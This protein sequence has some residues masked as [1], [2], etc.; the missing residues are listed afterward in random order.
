LKLKKDY[1]EILVSRIFSLF[2]LIIFLNQC[3]LDT[4]SGFWTETK[5][6]EKE[7]KVE[8]IF[9]S[10]RILEKEFNSNLN[11]KI[12][13]IYNQKPFINNL[14][15]N[16]GYINFE[17][18]FEK[19]S[20]FKFKKIKNF[21][22]IN[23]D[24]LIG[25]DDALTFFD[26]KGA[27]L[28]FNNNSKLIWK[29][30]YYNKNEIKQ[31]PV[32]NFATDG[33]I[34]IAADNLANLYALDYLNG[35][36]IWKNFNKASFNSE[37]KIFNDKVF[38]IDFENVIRCISIKN[39]KEI[40]NF[41]TEKSFIKSQRK[42][43]LIIQNDQVIF[44]DTFGDI[45]SLDINTGNLNWQTQTVNE[46]IY[47]SAFLLKNSKLVYDDDA[48]YVSNNQN[49]FFSINSKSGFINW[50]QK[51]NTYLD[52]S[53]IENLVIT[54]SEDGYLIIIDKRNGNILRSTNILDTFRNKKINPTGFIIAKN[55]IYVCLNN[56]KLLKVSIKDGKTKN[57][58]KIDNG[59]ISRP[60]VLNKHMYILRNDAIIKVE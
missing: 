17:S 57:I 51:I 12:N 53:V 15:N 35:S 24:L 31:R 33:K 43:S 16:V 32:I 49:K 30:N 27:I 9:K 40:W 19:I 22:F 25:N 18:N 34:L 52:P 55:F 42:L 28:K 44:I 60:Y 50:E 38:L 4:K 2:C 45:N 20:K 13:S 3:S 29:K 59:K 21:D 1:K 8:R 48:I 36:L 11:I 7:N 14:S 26:E 10:E 5:K 58:L 54:I 23:P 6:I 37:I 47:E 39:G 41:G 46:Y 56:G